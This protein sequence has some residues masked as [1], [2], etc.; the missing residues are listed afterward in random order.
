[1]SDRGERY[2][3]TVVADGDALVVPLSGPPGTRYRV[4]V[5]RLPG[6][7]APRSVPAPAAPPPA[8]SRRAAGRREERERYLSAIQAGCR[9]SQVRERARVSA[10]RM[11][12]LARETGVLPLRD[13]NL[14]VEGGVP[15]RLSAWGPR[16][17]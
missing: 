11:R 8:E 14:S 13:V 5:E 1:M 4:T 10:A 7:V 3:R 15:A 9:Y 6:P 2:E 16:R 12:S 17:R